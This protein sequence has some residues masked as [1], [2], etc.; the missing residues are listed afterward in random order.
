MVRDPE[1]I[2]AYWDLETEKKQWVERLFSEGHARTVLRIYDV[3]DVEFDLSHVKTF[4]D[5][6]VDLGTLEWYVHVQSF[7]RTLVA[8]L[9]IIDRFGRFH[10]IARSNTI[11]MPRLGPSDIIDE[12][13]MCVDFDEIY[14]L[15]G[16]FR[17]GGASEQLSSFNWSTSFS[18]GATSFVSIKKK[19]LPPTHLKKKRV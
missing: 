12:Q 13:W 6:E 15:S 9:A 18:P 8:D 16:G 7:D 11:R 1:W 10:V 5:V 14:A 17:I 4:W 2:F 19:K 3:T